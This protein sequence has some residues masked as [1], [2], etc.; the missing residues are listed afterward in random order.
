MKLFTILFAAAAA[1][2]LFGA[3]NLVKNGDFSQQEKLWRSPQYTGGKK[4]HTFDGD[5]L[6]VSG[7]VKAQYNAFASLTQQLPELDPSKEYLLRCEITAN[8]TDLNKKMFCVSVRHASAENKT[9]RYSEIR[10][11]L[12]KTATIPYAIKFRPT[13]NAAQFYL[14]VISTNL[15]DSDVVTVD[16]ISLEELATA[17]SAVTGNL[18]QNGDFEAQ[19]LKPWFSRVG[20][21]NTAPFA[22]VTDPAN[23]NRILTVNGDPQNK[24][25]NFLTLIQKLPPLMAGKKYQLKVRVKAGLENTVKKEVNIQ[26]RESDMDNVTVAY[27][28]IKA[29]LAKPG[30]QEYTRTFIPRVEADNFELYVSSSQLA[31]GDTVCVDDIILVPVK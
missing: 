12:K 19:S 6:I 26:V 14:Y 7:N 21:K 5:K 10:A 28:G 18:V 3:E 1:T 16:N 11:D 29:N 31:E 25:K 23:A 20:K 24:Y 4:F 30:W 2:G 22:V 13:A 9:L 27:T 8:V 17:Q 15:A